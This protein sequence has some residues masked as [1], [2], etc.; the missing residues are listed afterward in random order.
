VPP[1][2]LIAGPTA[3]GKSRLAV[4][5]AKRIG[6]EIINADSMQI[7]SDLKVLSAR[8]SDEEQAGVPHHLFGVAGSSERYSVGRWRR[9]ALAAMDA[10]RARGATAIFVG[11]TGL[12]YRALTMG[13]ADIPDPGDAAR[14]A[15]Q[16]LL[17]A[18][19]VV[20]LAREAAR[21]DPD[22]AARVD[23]TDTQRLM[24]IIA[25]AIGTGAALSQHQRQTTPSLAPG[26]WCGVVL[27]PD[28]AALT[29]RIAKRAEAMLAGGA[30]DEVKALLAKSP[31]DDA[32]V[33]RALGVETLRQF[34]EGGISR[35]EAL[36]RLT[37]E[38][39]Q[40]AKRQMT[41]FRNQTPDWPRID[42]LARD[43]GARLDAAL[44]EGDAVDRESSG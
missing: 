20:G 39:R 27:A 25:V 22:A 6:G 41:W 15:A 19:G 13:L 2:I 3:S 32:G 34:I 43:A 9:D 31:P 7:Y 24:R 38:T 11:G 26:Q 29:A 5:L 16:E 18:E 4:S 33:L 35:D 37:I 1:C 40:Y 12:Y 23:A 8:P 28:R 14:Q 17:D 36:E 44:A 42:P 21:L 10:V 30:I